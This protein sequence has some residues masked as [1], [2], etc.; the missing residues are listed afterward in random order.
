HGEFRSLGNAIRPALHDALLAGVEAHP[1]LSV[2]MH[3]TKQAGFPAAE[4]MPGHGHGDGNVNTHHANFN[5]TAELARHA[6]IAGKQADA[7]SVLVAIDQLY[8]IGKATDAHARQHGA[9]DFIFV[10][11]HFRR[12]VIEQRTAKPEA[13]FAAFTGVAG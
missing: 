8:G 3:V 6:A 5:A 13:V 7:I 9:E 11:A 10:D 1:F 4:A 2:G 12:D